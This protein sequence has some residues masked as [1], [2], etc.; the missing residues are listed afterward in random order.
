MPSVRVTIFYDIW[1]NEAPCADFLPKLSTP[2]QS[3]G[4]RR[5]ARE[6]ARGACVMPSVSKMGTLVTPK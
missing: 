5:L 1:L 6:M 2:R 3:G 4:I